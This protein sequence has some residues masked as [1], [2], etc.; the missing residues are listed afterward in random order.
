MQMKGETSMHKE[1]RAPDPSVSAPSAMQEDKCLTT[2]G[3]GGAVPSAS[4]PLSMQGQACSANPTSAGDTDVKTISAPMLTHAALSLDARVWFVLTCAFSVCALTVSSS[5]TLAFL[6]L[7][8]LA[9]YV[10]L[11]GNLALLGRSLALL[12]VLYALIVI[13]AALVFDGTGDVMIAGVVGISWA[14][15]ARG[16]FTCA[17]LMSIVV[18][19]LVL[20]CA[21]ATAQMSEALTGLLKLLGKVGFPAGDI[22][23]MLGLALRCIPL[24]CEKLATIRMAQNARGAAIGLSRNPVRKVLSY[25]PLMVPLCVA[26]FRYADDFAF[27]LSV[28]GFTGV[29]RVEL[30]AHAMSALDWLVAGAGVMIAAGLAVF[31]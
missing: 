13:S 19:S 2:E 16:A 28:K 30:H 23:I 9:L 26:M 3:L 18:F 24:A 21:C 15:F 4:V 22:A 5:L 8:A 25:V 10:R 31:C 14:G 7:G 17:R 20:T 11:G 27:S 12:G 29:N 6:W 1:F